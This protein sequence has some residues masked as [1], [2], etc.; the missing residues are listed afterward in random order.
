MTILIGSMIIVLIVLA[1][2]TIRLY[3]ISNS[4]DFN[5]DEID[6]EDTFHE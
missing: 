3:A 4:L 1:Y 5:D 6:T 2:G